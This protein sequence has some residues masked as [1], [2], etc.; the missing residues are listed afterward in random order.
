MLFKMVYE[1]SKHLQTIQPHCIEQNLAL[2]TPAGLGLCTVK[3][4]DPGSRGGLCS[5]LGKEQMARGFEREQDGGCEHWK[6]ENEASAHGSEFCLTDD[7]IPQPS[8]EQRF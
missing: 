3:G 8:A 1:S 6:E 7:C 5:M 2:K 4:R